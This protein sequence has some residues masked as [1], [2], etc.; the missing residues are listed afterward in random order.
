[1]TRKRTRVYYR[2]YTKRD[3]Q[4]WQREMAKNAPPAGDD[5]DQ[6]SLLLALGVST[7]VVGLDA[8][9]VTPLLPSIADELG[10]SIA[11]ASYTVSFYLLPYGLCQLAYGPLADRVGKLRVATF[12]MAAFSVGTAACGAF[13]GLTAL[14]A[15][16]AL[17]G[18]AAA[19]L[20]PLTIA[21]IGDTVPYSRRQATLGL[22][23]ASTGAAQ[24]LSTG[25]GGLMAEV[26]SW[27]SIFPVLGGLSALVTAWLWHRARRVRVAPSRALGSYK[28]ALRSG[29]SPLLWLVLAEGALFMGCFPFFSGL[30]DARFRSGPLA[31]GL[32]LAL[33]G[34][35]QVV[36]AKVLP[37]LLRRTTEARLVAFGGGLMAASYLLVAL[38][39]QVAWVGVSAVLLGAG[40]SLCHSTLQARATEAF[41]Q[42]RGRALALFAFSLFV[43]G[44]AGTF[45]MGFLTE[46]LGYG[47]SFGLAS[48]TFALF[49]HFAA[50]TVAA[51]GRR[52][53]LLALRAESNDAPLGG[54]ASS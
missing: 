15:L 52:A 4:L 10:C 7:F 5:P 51:E 49:A 12:A 48:V 47:R 19:A 36:V 28:E 53:R 33:A 8:R 6:R 42:G 35:V 9:I 2:R 37:Q 16:R 34:M 50:R 54:A 41:P 26:I 46:R 18:A 30:L 14:L 29:L 27:R 24:S 3:R 21:Y 44:G 39:S 22:L 23:M 31:I 25:A 1:M 20:I 40:F 43:G 32:T 38:A 13:G 11:A 45:A 17:T